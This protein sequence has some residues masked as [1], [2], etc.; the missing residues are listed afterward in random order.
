MNR[1]GGSTRFRRH[2]RSTLAWG[3]G[4][5]ILACVL[6]QPDYTALLELLQQAGPALLWVTLLEPLRWVT[7][8]AAWQLL[9][10]PG[11]RA[12]FA[13]IL[14][15]SAVASAVNELLPAFSVGGN[16]LKARHVVQRGIPGTQ[17]TAVGI[18]DIS[19]HAISALAWSLIGL[20]TLSTVADD[21]ELFR[22]SLLGSLLLV[23]VIL[24]FV[25]AQLF[26]SEWIATLL[27]R[28]FNARGWDRLADGA[29]HTRHC[30][31]G[32][33]RRRT[34]CLGSVLSRMTGR[35]LMVPEILFIGWL[36]GVDIALWQAM[37]VTGL[38]I[39]VKTASFMIPARIGVQEGAFL[40]VGALLGLQTEL[41][42]TIALTVR[43]RETLP[44]IPVLVI[45]WLTEAR[46]LTAAQAPVAENPPPP[47]AAPGEQV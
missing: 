19:L 9:F 27:Q 41:M 23:L 46:R 43:V 33:W 1:T 10:L 21:A 17:A 26:A 35:A 30:L 34:T 36:T 3:T 7:Q 40:A 39:L 5:A 18:V 24:L 12:G 20:S 22:A 32:I 31:L 42:F 8:A 38:V 47:R 4:S 29:G 16:L 45:W 13:T 25:G 37:T 44:Q 14:W 6:M 2:L 28:R 11:H 15:A